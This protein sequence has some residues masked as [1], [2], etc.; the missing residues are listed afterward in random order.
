MATWIS[1]A[2]L[3]DVF[4]ADEVTRAA[5]LDHDGVRDA[6][7]VGKAIAR[8]EGRI[9]SRLLTRY[10]PG[11]IPAGGGEVPEA[12]RRVAL[13]LAWYELHK[14]FD[15]IAD[16]VLR[17]RDDAVSELD[18]L[19][20]GAGSLGLAGNP[21]ADATRPLILTSPSREDRLTLKALDGETRC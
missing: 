5:D 6:G 8:A 12:L 13:G 9:R 3:D 14:R 17:V 21:P 10:Q 18:D 16:A 4:G 11:E 2:D 19:V 1:E 15:Q 7:V 20:N